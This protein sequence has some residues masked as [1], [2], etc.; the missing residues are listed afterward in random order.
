ME[1]ITE[2]KILSDYWVEWHSFS[3]NLKIIVF[4][5]NCDSVDFH[6][7]LLGQAKAY[8][9]QEVAE[10]QEE[11][12]KQVGKNWFFLL[13]V[14][15]FI[16]VP[17]FSLPILKLHGNLTQVERSKVY[18]EFN[19]TK[20][21]VLVC[22]DVAARGIDFPNIDWIIQYDPPEDPTEYIHRVIWFMWRVLIVTVKVGRT[23]RLGR[24]GNALLFL[25]P[26]E[27]NYVQLL[28]DHGVSNSLIL[29]IIPN[30][31]VAFIILH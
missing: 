15:D 20:R 23:A 13:N 12:K 5:S 17:L 30:T 4:F 8:F 2:V 9:T 25:L 27:Q 24:E 6:H 3:E 7:V 29:Q 16:S 18:N 21:G 19:K 26:S 28:K 11:Q 22:T 1:I 31:I 10:N 14:T